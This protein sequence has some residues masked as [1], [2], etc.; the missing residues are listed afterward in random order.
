MR[1]NAFR[2]VTHIVLDGTFFCSQELHR[3]LAAR[4]A[5]GGAIV[6]I[7][8]TQSFTGG[9]G[10][11]AQRRGQGRGGQPHQVAGR[12]VGAR[13]H[14]GQRPGAGA[15]PPRGH[16][17]RP[18]GPA[19]RGRVGRRPAVPGGPPGPAARAGLGRH[20]AVLALRRLRHRPHP[21]GGRGQLAAPG[22]RHARVHARGRPA[23]AGAAPGRLTCSR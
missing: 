23:V 13:R 19:P 14:P 21:G 22:L 1:P 5:A 7:L 2:A 6:N 4:G 20:L 17:R 15:V 11:G 3:R 18:Q 12:G 8:A 10:H 16:A 9:P